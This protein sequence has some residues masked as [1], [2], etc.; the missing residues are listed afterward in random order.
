MADEL[1]EGPDRILLATA[2]AATLAA[3]RGALPEETLVPLTSAGDLLAAL[4]KHP[5][6]IVL[7]HEELPGLSARIIQVGEK[8]SPPTGPVK[9]ASH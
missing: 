3:V 4:R 6:A 1:I 2:D 5:S 7:L 9:T 8:P